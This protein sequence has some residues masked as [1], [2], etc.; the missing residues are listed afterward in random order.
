M[1]RTASRFG[2]RRLLAGLGTAAFVGL[3]G[4]TGGDGGGGGGGDGGDGGDGDSNS[5]TPSPESGEVNVPDLDPV[6]QMVRGEPRERV[7][8]YL[9]DTRNYEGEIMDAMG[10]DEIVVAVG[11][12]GNGGNF[13]YHYPAIAVSSGTT[14][15]WRWT[16]K[17]GQHNVVSES[18]TEFDFS[19]G[20]PKIEGEPFEHTFEGAGI[21]LYVCEPHA[22][23]GMK[24]AVV[25]IEG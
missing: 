8:G 25:V 7:E 24:G 21:G 17:G 14:V 6:N 16:G 4:C 18:P 10:R 22:S 23:L 15:S 5:P 3:A 1:E 11:A 12:E 19:S 13:A 9:S 2:R 20:P